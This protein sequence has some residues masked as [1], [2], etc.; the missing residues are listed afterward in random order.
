MP[1][2]LHPH[3][4]Q[5]QAILLVL[6]AMSI[7]LLAAVGLTIDGAQVYSQW[8]MAQAAADAGAQAG[9]MSIFN[10]TNAGANPF[11]TGTP[12]GPFTCSTTDGRTPCVYARLNGFGGTAAD[13]VSVDFPTSAPGVTLS[14][15]D[16]V[17]LIRVT[18]QRNVDTT[19]M[20]LLGPTTS[21]VTARATAAIVDVLAPTP[22]I[23]THPSLPGAL[24][25]NGNPGIQI[26][27]GPSR[28]I[29]VNSRN[30]A[31]LSMNSN[32]TV[33]LSRAGPLDNG[34]CATGTGA[35][36]GDF[37]GPHTPPFTF[38]A[39]TKGKYLQPASPIQDPFATVPEPTQP[40]AGS[41]AALANGVSGCPASPA[42]PCMLYSP[43]TFSDIIV[44]NETAVFKPGLYYISGNGGFKNQANGEMLMATGFAADPNTGAGMVVY[45]AGSGT[46]D[47]GSNSDANLLGSDDTS[48]YKSILFFNKRT[49]AANTG[50]G[51]SD[52]HKFG[53]GGSL[54]LRGTIYIN[55]HLNLMEGGQYQH[56]LLQGTPG[57]QTLIQ[58]HIVVGTLELGGNA[59]IRMQLNPS[60]QLHVRQVALVQ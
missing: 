14:T 35:D 52:E 60:L 5:G 1:R 17:N 45:N 30:A 24:S 46:F 9:I 29:Q 2:N 55:N 36:F 59:T 58:G 57:S 22:I 53:G 8:Q 41:K 6:V 49:A 16:P 48:I 47:V 19:L 44:H 20:R 3:S 27:G 15:V 21:A 13:T 11:G 10:G 31:S 56:V 38:L 7:F 40:P 12:P 43:G 39:G 25:S 28:S 18:V 34:L 50:I 54:I 23:V 26:C 4:E 32:T 33:D 37:G 51:S 42:K